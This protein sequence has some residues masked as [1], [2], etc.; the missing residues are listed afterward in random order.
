MPAW[1]GAKNADCISTLNSTIRCAKNEPAPLSPVEGWG[2]VPEV[3]IF[4]ILYGYV[5]VDYSRAAKYMYC[6][7]SSS[8][9]NTYMLETLRE[10]AVASLHCLLALPLGRRMIPSPVERHYI[11]FSCV[12]SP[13]TSWILYFL[14]FVNSF[15]YLY[16]INFLK[17]DT[18]HNYIVFIF[19]TRN[20]L[21]TQK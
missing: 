9:K 11:F 13:S 10:M 14:A 16:T 3:P 19:N 15:T 4:N 8:R 2:Y 7:L 6:H 5:R 18:S 17:I 21:W 20:L 1:D 12:L